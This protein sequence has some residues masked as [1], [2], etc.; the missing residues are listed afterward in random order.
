MERRVDQIKVTQREE[1]RAVNNSGLRTPSQRIGLK[2]YEGTFPSPEPWH[3]AAF[4]Q[5]DLANAVNQ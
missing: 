4:P 5:S 1:P 3:L 2:L